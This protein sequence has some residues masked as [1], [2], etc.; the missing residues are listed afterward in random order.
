[1]DTLKSS[2]MAEILYSRVAPLNGQQCN[3][4]HDGHLLL[5]HFL[6]F[7]GLKLGLS[8][9]NPFSKWALGVSLSKMF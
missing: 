8:K 2:C 3:P 5:L 4:H 1:M 7:P 6:A 9:Y